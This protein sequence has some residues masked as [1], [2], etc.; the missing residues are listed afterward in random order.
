MVMRCSSDVTHV[1]SE[2]DTVQQSIRAVCLDESD[3]NEDTVVVKSSWLSECIKA[4]RLVDVGHEHRLPFGCASSQVYISSYEHFC[5][6]LAV[7][8]V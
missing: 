6:E 7:N 8:H 1:I 4:G 5:L 2:Y 3:W